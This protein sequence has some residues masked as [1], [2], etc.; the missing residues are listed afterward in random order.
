[1]LLWFIVEMMLEVMVW[2]KLNGLL[3][4]IMKLFMCSWLLLFSGRVVS[5]L[6]GMWISVML[7]FWFELMNLVL[8]VCLLVRVI[9]MLLVLLMMW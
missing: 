1:M 4:V 9:C 3:M 5:L 2:L 7:V 8:I 6:V